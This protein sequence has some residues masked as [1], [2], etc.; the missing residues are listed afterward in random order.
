MIYRIKTKSKVFG[1]FNEHLLMAEYHTRS[2]LQCLHLEGGQEYTNCNFFAF[3]SLKGITQKLTLRSA[4][5]QNG[6]AEPI[7]RSIFFKVKAMLEQNNVREI[8]WSDAV[9]TAEIIHNR[10]TC[11]EVPNNKTLTACALDENQNLL[12]CE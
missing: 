10:A 3:L 12:L 7:N 8:I 9:A 4:P 5:W 2:T 6:A 11:A 1:R